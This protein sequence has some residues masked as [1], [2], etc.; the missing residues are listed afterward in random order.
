M[1][2][3]GLQDRSVS[4]DLFL[5]QKRWFV[6]GTKNGQVCSWNKSGSLCQEQ[7]EG[8]VPGTKNKKVMKVAGK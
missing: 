3:A 5:E 8:N 6:P 1:G 2:E 7:K 4:A